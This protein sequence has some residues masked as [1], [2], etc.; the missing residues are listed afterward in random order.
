MKKWISF[1]S[2]LGILNIVDFQLKLEMILWYNN[3]R[4]ISNYSMV[5]K[6]EFYHKVIKYH[7]YDI[8]IIK[9]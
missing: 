5:F 3:S 7:N 2:Y 9:T 4:A 1:C 8:K 6:N